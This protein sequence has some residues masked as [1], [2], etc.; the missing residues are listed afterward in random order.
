[1]KK[2]IIYCRVSTRKQ[3]DN[4]ASLENQEKA[5]REYCKS[6]NIE[7]IDTFTEAFTGTTSKRP[8]FEKALSK[9]IQENIDYFIIFDIDRFSREGYGEFNRLK[10]KLQVSNIQLRDSK[11]IIWERKLVVENE[12]YDMSKYDWAHENTSEYAEVFLAT[13]ASSEARKIKQRT[14][15]REIQLEQMWYKVRQSNFGYLNKR[16]DTPDG[17]KATIQIKHPIEWEWMIEMFKNRAKGTMTD[18]QIVEQLNLKGYASRKWKKL[19][20]KQLQVFMT[21]PIYAGIVV[22]EWTWYSAIKAPYEGLIDIDTWNKANRWKIKVIELDDKEIMIEYTNKGEPTINIP[23]VQKRKNYNSDFPL[24]K[25]L[26]CPHCNGVM[27]G[28][29]SKSGDGTIHHYY[30][31]NGKGKWGIKHKNYT[32]RR[33]DCHETLEHMLQNLDIKPEVFDLFDIVTENVFK[34]RE[35]EIQSD[36][37][38]YT[39]ALNNL[40]QKEKY[41]IDNL[42]NIL[43]LPAI[44]EKKNQELEDIKKE[45][46]KVEAKSKEVSTTTSLEKFKTHSKWLIKHLDKLAL[47][48]E[49]PELIQLSFDIIFGWRVEY[50]NINYQTQ[51]FTA[52]SP[53]LSQQKNPSEE[54]FSSNLLW[55]AH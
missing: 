42:D 36:K 2:W 26:K 9:S 52:F 20:V 41:I 18:E 28:N 5:C 29:P 48:K 21:R 33:D 8:E 38:D 3:Q 4:W 37:E 54:E 46:Q 23:T 30:Q 11:N 6:Q 14:I 39:V 35:T 50:E 47:Q 43:H 44:L 10:S 27:T 16:V 13:Q 15:P 40:E 17:K 32:I 45:K 24:A 53:N 22:W 51:F 55:Q 1:M 31:C 49:N 25:V 19:T 7:V 12:N 34:E